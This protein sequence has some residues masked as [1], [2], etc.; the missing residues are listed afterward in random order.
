MLSLF[1]LRLAF[2]ML[3]A[4]LLLSPAQ[5]NPRFYRTHFLTALGLGAGALVLLG[6]APVPARAVL[7]AA[8]LLSFLGSASWSIEGAPCGRTLVVLAALGFGAALW[9]A[10]GEQPLSGPLWLAVDGLTSSALLGVALTAMLMGHSYLIAPAMSLT[11]L[12]R[13]LLG[14]FVALALRMVFAAAGLWCWTGAE[15]S[16]TL[17]EVTLLWLPLRWGLGFVLPLVLGVMAWQTA[18]LRNTQSATG[19]L[20]IVVVFCFLGELTAQLLFRVTHY[21]L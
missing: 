3:A 6:D 14:L 8:L 4:L 2:G 1:F 13:L 21:F 10:Q 5:I 18:R 19:I 16:A 15:A 7:T 12:R 9:L 20:Y 11:P 17:K